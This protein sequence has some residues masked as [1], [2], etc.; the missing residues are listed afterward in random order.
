MATISST[1]LNEWQ[2]G[3]HL[4][5]MAFPTLFPRGVG[6]LQPPTGHRRPREVSIMDWARHL[7]KYK[8]GRFGKHRRFRYVAFNMHYRR[9]ADRQARYATKKVTRCGSLWRPAIQSNCRLLSLAPPTKFRVH[10]H[11]GQKGET[12][13]NPWCETLTASSRSVLQICSGRISTGTCLPPVRFELR[14]APRHTEQGMRIS[15]TILTLLP[16]G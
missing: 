12:S 10:A 5:A 15:P 8:D 3:Q 9:T 11:F 7:L 14:P 13:S 2:E 4:F 6:D 1:P 16:R